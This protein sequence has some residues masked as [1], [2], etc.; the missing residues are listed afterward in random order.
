MQV[1]LQIAARVEAAVASYVS[2]RDTADFTEW[3]RFF[4]EEKVSSHFN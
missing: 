2:V 4:I 3:K 1:L